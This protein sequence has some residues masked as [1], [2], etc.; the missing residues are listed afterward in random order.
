MVGRSLRWTLSLFSFLLRLYGYDAYLD[1]GE[2]YAPCLDA[3]F[4]LDARHMLPYRSLDG[5]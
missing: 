1:G 3:S 2:P 4:Q 5:G